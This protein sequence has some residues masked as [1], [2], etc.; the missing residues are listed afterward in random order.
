MSS[1]ACTTKENGLSPAKQTLECVN[2]LPL[3]P[4][5]TASESSNNIRF[6]SMFQ[7]SNSRT[8]I[9]RQT[10]PTHQTSEESVLNGNHTSSDKQKNKDISNKLYNSTQPSDTNK[11]VVSFQSGNSG[12]N[13]TVSNSSIPFRTPHSAQN[14]VSSGNSTRPVN[15]PAAGKVLKN[16]SSGYSSTKGRQFLDINAYS[17]LGKTNI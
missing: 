16:G 8:K 5:K 4:P 6:L 9:Q 12:G 13:H 15:K 10:I 3:K 7:N 1:K 17:L 2:E 14:I 11:M